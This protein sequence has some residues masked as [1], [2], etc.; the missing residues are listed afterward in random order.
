MTAG[1]KLKHYRQ[2][3]KASF[4]KKNLQLKVTIMNQEDRIP[5][6]TSPEFRVLSSARFFGIF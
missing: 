6:E 5:M 3:E 1:I 2:H 4:Q